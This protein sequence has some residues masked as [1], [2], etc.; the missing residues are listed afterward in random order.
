MK[1]W[2]ARLTLVCDIEFRRVLREAADRR[3]MSAVGY[4]RRATAAFIA[5]DLELPFE[6]VVAL[7][8]KPSPAEGTMKGLPVAERPIYNPGKWRDDGVGHGT[9]LVC[10]D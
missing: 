3:G 6:A 10:S 7:T 9:W 5:A 8:P 2:P 4:V 1:N